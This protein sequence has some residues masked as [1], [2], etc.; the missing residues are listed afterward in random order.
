M[1]EKSLAMELLIDYKKQF[2]ITVAVLSSIIVILLSIII[3][4][5]YIDSKFETIEY[6]QDGEGYNNINTGTQGDVLNG[7]EATDQEKEKWE[8]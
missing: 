1:E 4:D 2:K 5:A 3:Y 7:T 6:T 8:S